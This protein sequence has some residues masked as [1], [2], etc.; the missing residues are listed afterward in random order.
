MYKEPR[1]T[2]HADAS[3]AKGY[4][5]NEFSRAAEAGHCRFSGR[6]MIVGHPWGGDAGTLCNNLLTRPRRWHVALTRPPPPPPQLVE[7]YSAQERRLES[8]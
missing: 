5:A 6:A 3:S 1:P 7:A 4:S 2:C 8:R